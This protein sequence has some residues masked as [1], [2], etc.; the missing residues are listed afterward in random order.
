MVEGP[1]FYFGRGRAGTIDVLRQLDRRRPASR[2]TSSSR[3]WSTVRSSPARAM[4]K[5]IAEG[6]VRQARGLLTQPYRIRGMVVHGAG[7]GAKLG[8][9]TANLDAIDTLAARPPACTPVVAFVGRS[10]LGRRRST[11]ARIRRSARTHLKVEVH[12]VGWD[13]SP[14]YGQ[15]LEVDFLDELARHAAVRR[16]RTTL[17]AQLQ[18]DVRASPASIPRLRTGRSSWRAADVLT[19]DSNGTVAAVR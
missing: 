17:V 5:L 11:S 4:R 13:G 9:G 15:P 3:W 2:S 7:R 8:F 10:P 6:D 16:R 14:L 12:L 1:N 19:A 18:D